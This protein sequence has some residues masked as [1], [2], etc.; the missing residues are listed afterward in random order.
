MN[1]T[2]FFTKLSYRSEQG[3][4][5]SSRK[6][7]L[8]IFLLGI[9][10]LI[11]IGIGLAYLVVDGKW[12]IA[13][14]FLS[15]IPIVFTLY[16]FP[17]ITLVIWLVLAP[18]L[19]QTPT[20]AERQIYWLVHRLLPVLTLGIMVLTSILRISNR[21]LPRFTLVEYAMLGYIGVTVLSIIFQNNSVSTTVIHFYD[22]VFIPMC[23][24]WIIRF[25]T[26]GEKSLKWLLPIAAFIALTQIGI[27]S[28]SWVFPSVLPS[29]WLKYQGART[30]GSLNSVGVFTTTIIFASVIVL[31]KVVEMKPGWKRNSLIILYLSTIYAIFI[32]FSRASWLAGVFFLLCV[33]VIYP[34]FITRMFVRIFPIVLLVGVTIMA[35]QFK[36]ASERLYS[37]GSTQSALSRLPV[38]VAAYRM[39]EQKPI[40]GWGYENFDRYDRQY[41]GRFGNLV[42]PDEKD[43]TSHN[44]YLTLLAEQGVVGFTLALLPVLLLLAKT[45]RLSSYLS[46]DGLRNRKM[47]SLLWAV[48]ASFFIIN[49]FA[50]MVVFFGLGLYW[51]TLGLIANIL[52]TQSFAR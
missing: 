27:G 19:V 48:F 49:N 12:M 21:Y 44:M 14:A 51:V 36:K 25:A 16:H 43:H 52:Q 26:P 30:T 33:F 32:S 23:L 22:R 28:L 40:F 9:P 4:R 13:A 5:L 41:Q 47:L 2:S 50:P 46:K 7:D 3:K 20:T 45:R 29:G 17:F 10:G 39:F 37:E 1:K 18:F 42:N 8:M 15:I 38:Y 11:V 6:N 35:T 34:R 24:Y 31:H